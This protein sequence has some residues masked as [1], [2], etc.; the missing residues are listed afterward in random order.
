MSLVASSQQPPLVPAISCLCFNKDRSLAALSPANSEIH[1]YDTCHSESFQHWTLQ[2]VLSEHASYITALD[3]AP[4]SNKL[5]SCSQDKNCFVWEF[6]SSENNDKGEWKPIPVLIYIS[7]SATCCKW[8]PDESRF[9]VGSSSKTVSICCYDKE[10]RFYYSKRFTKHKSTVTCLAWH[11]HDPTLLL[12]GS[13]DFKSRLFKVHMN[14]LDGKNPN[15]DQKFGDCLAEFHSKGWLHDVQFS[16][17]GRWIA[18]VAHDST[19]QFVDLNNFDFKNQ[20]AQIV[21][22][23]KL[24]FTRGLFLSD[25]SFIAVG[26]DC[27]PYAFA[28]QEGTSQWILKG[29]CDDGKGVTTPQSSSGQSVPSVKTVIGRIQAQNVV[30]LHNLQNLQLPT[31]RH[32]RSITSICSLSSMSS[33]QKEFCIQKFST[34]ALDGRIVYWNLDELSKSLGISLY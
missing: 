30:G 21:R 5:L 15:K 2:H 26:H 1:I 14:E 27:V 31:T 24:P 29:S 19:V 6:H 11:P 32:Y 25:H 4:N 23:S 13:C 16:P 28:L 12:T 3:W 18:L 7:K 20:L 22:H 33:S 8:S 17:S 10:N 34:A 9:A